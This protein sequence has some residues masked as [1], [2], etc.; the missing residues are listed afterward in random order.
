[1]WSPEPI[2]KFL[3]RGHPSAPPLSRVEPRPFSFILPS[4]KIHFSVGFSFIPSKLCFDGS[5]FSPFWEP[6]GTLCRCFWP[7]CSL[8]L[9]HIPYAVGATP[10]GRP[11]QWEIFISRP[12]IGSSFF[13]PN[14]C[15]DGNPITFSA[16]IRKRVFHSAK[17]RIGTSVTLA[18]QFARFFTLY[19]YIPSC[20][21]QRAEYPQG[22]TKPPFVIG[23]PTSSVSEIPPNFFI[24]VKR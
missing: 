23:R 6:C 16:A 14:L 1:M 17:L 18:G 24:S 13:P 11:N 8:F 22:R 21:H 2:G 20:L 12:S 19:N 10:C 15:F 5:P 9:V 3:F 7:I 4:A